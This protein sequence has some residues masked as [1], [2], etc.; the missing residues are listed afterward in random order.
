MWISSI[1]MLGFTIYIGLG[2]AG[3]YPTPSCGCAFI[4][5][6]LTW[7]QHFIFNLFFL[8]LSLLGIWLSKPRHNQEDPDTRYRKPIRLWFKSR[9][10]SITKFVGVLLI[11]AV[12]PRRKHALYWRFAEKK[13]QLC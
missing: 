8:T 7:N 6:S 10:V 9:A 5:E 1:L 2:I 4:I 11:R 12:H 13:P 3:L